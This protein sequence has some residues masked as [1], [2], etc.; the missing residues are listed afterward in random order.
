MKLNDVWLKED[1][2]GPSQGHSIELEDSVALTPLP[3]GILNALAHTN[4]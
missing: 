2:W 1:Q 3:A 4:F